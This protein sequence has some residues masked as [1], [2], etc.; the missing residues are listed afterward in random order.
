M[1]LRRAL[2]MSTV[3]I[4]LGMALLA[5]SGSAAGDSTDD[6]PKYGPDGKLLR[7]VDYRSWIYLSSGLGMNYAPSNA[8]HQMFT[9]VFVN[10][11][12]YRYFKQNGRWPDKTIFA[13]ELYAPQSHGS[14]NKSGYYQSSFMGLEAEVKD[15]SKGENTWAYYGLGTDSESAKPFPKE[16]CWMCHTKSAAVENTFVQFYPKLLE[17]AQ[18]KGTLKAGVDIPPSTERVYKQVVAEGWTRTEPDVKAELSKYPD[19]EAFQEQNLNMMGYA[20]LDKD[21]AKDAVGVFRFTAERFPSSLNAVDSL[22]DG[23]EKAGDKA[24]A[25]AESE[26]EMKMT[27]AASDLTPEMKDMARKAV[28]ERMARLKGSK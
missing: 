15:E 23:L 4:L 19:A 14:I 6:G 1:S 16:D 26:K 8:S 9:N 10:P 13:L 7:P 25:I 3:M 12:A 2:V 24:G 28:Q 11:S 22:A 21:R 27:E 18:S 20:L 5:R 17:V